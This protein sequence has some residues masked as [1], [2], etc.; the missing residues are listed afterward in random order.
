M[1]SSEEV[2]VIKSTIGVLETSGEQLTAY[3]YNRLFREHPE[4]AKYFNPV[5]QLKGGQ[6]RALADAI[7]AYANNIETPEVL[8]SAV[9][10]IAQK[11]VSLQV[12][13]EHYPVVG[14][15]LLASISE[16]LELPED[17][18]ILLAWGKAY[19]ILADLFI[20]REKQ[21]Y[22][23]LVEKEH[24]WAG[25]KKLKV[26]EIVEESSEVRSYFLVSP[27][28]E[29]PSFDPG[30]YITLRLPFEDLGTTMRHYS[31][32]SKPGDP[33]FRI[34]V[35][36]EDAQE[37]GVPHGYVSNYLA[38]ELK[39]GSYV[40]VAMPCG[41]FKLD[42]STS[43]NRPLVFLAGGVGVTPLISMLHSALE[44]F[45]KREICFIQGARSQET[46]L[47]QEELSKLE[48]Q[49]KSL[50]RY[51]RFSEAGAEVSR[52]R[53]S[54]GFVDTEFLKETLENRDSEY[55]FCG[56]PLFL[57]SVQAT[58]QTWEISEDQIHFEFFTPKQTLCPVERATVCTRA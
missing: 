56:P 46:L 4:V 51:V 55:Y 19:T 7:C 24:G 6:Q 41:D 37:G 52:E 48:S 31:L 23:E 34:S 58:L 2:E 27:E 12:Q 49:F 30:Q 28:G 44:T 53:Q 57:G 50:S 22:T 43:S 10:L 16:V 47:F 18:P 54:L 39:K 11:H 13:P 25:F 3:F 20:G 32:S 15:N 21:I 5:N 9:E 8:S 38:N 29:L 17:D 14:E 33:Y 45:P 35:K 42:V 36:K 26:S 1:L 40:E